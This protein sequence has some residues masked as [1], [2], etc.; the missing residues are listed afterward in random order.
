MSS[1]WRE[2]PV[3]LPPA[4]AF[5]PGGQMAIGVSAPAG[6]TSIQRLPSPKGASARFSRPSASV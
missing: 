2:M 3:S 4:V 6:A 5:G 1:V